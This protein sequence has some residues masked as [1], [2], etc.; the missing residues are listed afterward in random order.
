MVTGDQTLSYF[1]ALLFLTTSLIHCTSVAPHIYDTLNGT[2]KLFPDDLRNRLLVQWSKKSSETFDPSRGKRILKLLE[3]N[4]GIYTNKEKAQYSGVE[5]TI[6]LSVISLNEGKSINV[7][8]QILRNWLCYTAHYDYMPVVY[9]L[10]DPSGAN[11]TDTSLQKINVSSIIKDLSEI[12]KNAIFIDY[13]SHLFWSLLSE[14]TLWDSLR[15]ERNVV[16]FI[17]DYPT[18][19]HFGALVMLVPFLEVLEMGFSVIYMD[20]DIALVKD[21]IPFIALGQY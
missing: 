11:H 20:I 7:Y 19:P 12:N 2:L 17:G 9:F 1:F 4:S 14:K 16:D 18:F 3:R 21:P 10:S 6:L 15:K 5:R 8:R 13:P